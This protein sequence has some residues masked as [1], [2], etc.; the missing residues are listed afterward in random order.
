MS[1]QTEN[2]RT[3]LTPVGTFL[4]WAYTYSKACAVIGDEW[5]RP[6]ISYEVV[7]SGF[8]TESYGTILYPGGVF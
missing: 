8:E 2:Y 5:Q 4:C 1:V 7:V 3:F 6:P